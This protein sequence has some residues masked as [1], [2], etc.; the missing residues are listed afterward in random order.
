[1]TESEKAKIRAF[2]SDTGM[3]TTVKNLL[4]DVFL[5]ARIPADVNLLAAQTLAYQFLEDGWRTME[6]YREKH[7]DTE[8]EPVNPG[9]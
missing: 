2:M 7:D 3:Q 4:R 8:K 1:M 9:V 6:R 5:E